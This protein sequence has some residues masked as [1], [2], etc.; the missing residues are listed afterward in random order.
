MDY[1]YRELVFAQKDF[2]LVSRFPFFYL[3]VVVVVDCN[4]QFSDFCN[5]TSTALVSTQQTAHIN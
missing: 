4:I 5:Q 2:H 3:V 1:G